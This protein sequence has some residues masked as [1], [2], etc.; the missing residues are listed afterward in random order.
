[1]SDAGDTKH[2]STG[3]GYLKIVTNN[4]N[5][6]PH[7][8]ALVHCWLTPKLRHA[9]FSPGA[10]VKRHRT[11]FSDCMAYNNFAT[12]RGHAALHAIA[13]GSDVVITGKLLRTSLYMEPLVIYSPVITDDTTTPQIRLM[14]FIE[15][16]LILKEDKGAYNHV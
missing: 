5:G 13:I 1:M 14:I 12:G 4:A 9:V 7:R 3:F 6:A 11:R 8:F 10:T 2:R 15:Q 16:D